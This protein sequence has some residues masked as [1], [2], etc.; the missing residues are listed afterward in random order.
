MISH[1]LNG[2]LHFKIAFVHLKGFQGEMEGNTKGEKG[3]E[4]DGGR[5]NERQ[6]ERSR[7][8]FFQL[9]HSPEDGAVRTESSQ[10]QK[11]GSSSGSPSCMT[12][13]QDSGHFALFY[14]GH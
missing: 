11:P 13:A 9:V 3:A 6:R 8:T 7:F 2:V 1:G 4:K 12:G 14:S 5:D 10:T